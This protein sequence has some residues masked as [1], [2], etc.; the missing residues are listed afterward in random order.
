MSAETNKSAYLPIALGFN[1]WEEGKQ[2]ILTYFNIMNLQT[3]VN[4]NIY[5]VNRHYDELKVI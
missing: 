5:L 4:Y 3:R 2:I 1:V